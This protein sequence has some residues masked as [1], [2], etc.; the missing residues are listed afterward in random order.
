MELNYKFIWKEHQNADKLA[1]FIKAHNCVW[2]FM[3]QIIWLTLAMRVLFLLFLQQSMIFCSGKL[4]NR[5]RFVCIVHNRTILTL[6]WISASNL[7]TRTV[8]LCR[9][10][11]DFGQ[12]V[13]KTS[14]VSQGTSLCPL[15]DYLDQRKFR[16]VSMN[17]RESNE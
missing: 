15:C 14:K 8:I 17:W 9:T 10:V 16:K 11:H 12:V 4:P 1:W 2:W 5:R 6:T 13:E 7:Q 3:V